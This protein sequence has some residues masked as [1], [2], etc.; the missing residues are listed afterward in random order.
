MMASLRGAG[1]RRVSDPDLARVIIVN[2]CG[3]IEPAKQESIDT[4]LQFSSQY[5]DAKIVMAGCLSQRYPD[6]IANELPELS[7]V[8][9]NRRPQRI[10]EYLRAIRESEQRVF[11]EESEGYATVQRDSLLSL[12]GSAFV[13]IAEGCDNRC[14]FCAIPLIRGPLRSRPVSDIVDEVRSLLSRGIREINL[15]AQDL[16]AYGK[17]REDGLARLVDAL[18]EIEEHFWIRP[19]YVYPEHFPDELIRAC[20]RDSRLLPYFDLPI[21]HGSPEVLRRMGRPDDPGRNI[22]L[23]ERIRDRLPDAFLRSTFLVGFYGETDREFEQ[24]LDFQDRAQ[25]DWLG[26]F[27]YS[28][29]D[30]TPAA[31]FDGRLDLPGPAAES[32]RDEVLRRQEPI[33]RGRVDRLVGRTLDVLIEELLR[34]SNMAIGRA[35]AHAPEVDGAVVITGLSGGEKPGSFL[36]CRVARRN[37]LDVE[38]VPL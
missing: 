23:I 26:V 6:E 5:P 29:E 34:D 18:L 35:Y 21:Q 32:R 8:V 31:R 11:T 14:S 10:D 19:L 30:G 28:P 22:E 17:D 3:F 27:T 25:F 9:G 36:R 15:V 24:L 7:A 33:T 4:V 38:A 37:G 2:S 12:P 16:A 1:W 20:E 13:K